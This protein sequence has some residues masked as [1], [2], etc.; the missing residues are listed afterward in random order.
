MALSVTGAAK[1]SR[2]DVEAEDAGAALQDEGDIKYVSEPQS[3][4]LIE[5]QQRTPPRKTMTLA[6]RFPLQRQR[7]RGGDC[8]T[9]S[10]MS[11]LFRPQHVIPSP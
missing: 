1:R 7:R 5:S 8:P 9:R 3:I 6:L 11:P 2:S 4:T 10:S